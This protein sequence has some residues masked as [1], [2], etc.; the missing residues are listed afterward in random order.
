MTGVTVDPMTR[1]GSLRDRLRAAKTQHDASVTHELAIPGYGGQLVARY[2]TLDWRAR[3]KIGLAVTGPNIPA[4]ELDA[5]ADILIASCD[6][7]DAHVDGAVQPLEM[8]LGRELAVFLGDEGAETD[9][10]GVLLIFP[11]E[12]A[13]MQHVEQLAALQATADEEADGEIAGN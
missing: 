12:L 9:R 13:L 1:T 4:R 2:H 11:S 3:R 10:Q 8:K 5:A 6:G 7:V